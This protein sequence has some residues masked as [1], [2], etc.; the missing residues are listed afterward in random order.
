MPCCGQ[1]RA[2]LQTNQTVAARPFPA[3]VPVPAPTTPPPVT[4]GAPA[5][6][7][8][9]KQSGHVVVRGPKTGWSYEFSTA[10]PVQ[11]V[12][13]RDAQLLIATGLFEPAG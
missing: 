12:E 6:R 1:N 5:P 8:R 4:K 13:A 11:P 7:L 3:T 9:Y 10:K 2:T